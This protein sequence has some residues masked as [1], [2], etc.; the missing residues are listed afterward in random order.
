ME[1][2]SVRLVAS[3]TLKAEKLLPRWTAGCFRFR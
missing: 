2:A 3:V 1:S